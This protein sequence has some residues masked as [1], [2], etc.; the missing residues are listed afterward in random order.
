MSSSLPYR[1]SVAA[2]EWLFISGQIGVRGNGLPHGVAAQTAQALDNLRAVL[3]SNGA[4]LSD[5]VKTTVFLTDM[6][7]YAEMNEQYG[8]VFATDPPSRSAVAVH[9]LPF[10]A[11]VEI[12]AIARPTG[13]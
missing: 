3:E 9:E 5:V 10:G 11:L 8:L 12:E 1:S 6:V 7:D 13:S 4:S 2:G